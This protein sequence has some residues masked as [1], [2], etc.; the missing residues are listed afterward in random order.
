MPHAVVDGSRIYYQ[1]EG[2]CD[3]VPPILLVHGAPGTDHTWFAPALPS[4]SR[5]SQVIVFDHAGH[6]RS[7]EVDPDTLT[8]ERLAHDIEGLRRAL[9]YERVHLLGHSFGGFIALLY[10]LNYPTR[11]GGLILVGTGASHRVQGTSTNV[12]PQR[13]SSE[14]LAARTHLWSGTMEGAIQTNDDLRVAFERALP[15]Y[16]FQSRLCPA[17]LPAMTF[18]IAPRRA[19]LIR[20]VPGYDVEDRLGEIAIP[21]L[22]AVGRHDFITPLAESELLARRIPNAELRVFENSGHMPFI[23]ET[24]RFCEIVDGFLHVDRGQRVDG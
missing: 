1:I 8:L 7:D 12:L 19:I 9:G 15:A 5:G 23:E 3:D 14:V 22:V 2:T 24:E 21:T 18:R 11:V 20:E 6:G 4:L 17:T 13:V 16:Y 10:A